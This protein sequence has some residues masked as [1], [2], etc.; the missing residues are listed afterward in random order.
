MS[1]L[2]RTRVLGDWHAFAGQRRFVGVEIGVFDDAGVG[3]D[4]VAGFDEDDVAGDDLARRNAL[5]LA[6]AHDGG[7][8][9]RQRHQCAHRFFG[10]RLLDEAEHR[11]EHDDERDDDRFVGQGGFARIL[12]QPFDHRDDDGDEE[13]DHQEVLELLEQPLPPRRFGRA[14]S[15]FGPYW[16]RRCFASAR[17]RPRVASEPSSN[18]TAS[19]GLLCGL[20]PSGVARAFRRTGAVRCRIKAGGSWFARS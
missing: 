5:A 11:V 18:T 2:E 8:R 16:S 19:A 20:V 4:L 14:L 6:V 12:Q 7:F 17:C 3:R 15:S 10:A 1:S 13:D 9:R